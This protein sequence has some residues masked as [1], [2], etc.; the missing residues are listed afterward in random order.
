MS[1]VDGASL[2]PLFDFEGDEPEPVVAARMRSAALTLATLH[3]LDPVDIGLADEPVVGPDAE[4]DRWCRLLETIDPVLVPG[5]RDV[6]AAL[7]EREPAPVPATVVHGDF[8]LGNLLAVGPDVTAVVD[9]EIWTLGD[10]RVDVG[11]F[12]ANADPAT[13]ER[14]TRYRGGTPSPAELLDA[15][16][17]AIGCAVEDVAWFRALACFKSAATWSLDEFGPWL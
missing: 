8:R 17:G 1:F 6:A 15:Y 12:L 4:V 7:Q 11:W 16:T 3:A 13:Y 10:P 14:P 5:W 9:W 2:E